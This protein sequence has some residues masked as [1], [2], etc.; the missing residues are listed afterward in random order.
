MSQGKPKNSNHKA[1]NNIMSLYTL[2]SIKVQ[3][4]YCNSNYQY[5]ALFFFFSF[6]RKK[7][8]IIHND[9]VSRVNNL[10]GYN[11]PDSYLGIPLSIFILNITL[12]NILQVKVMTYYQ[13]SLESAQCRTLFLPLLVRVL[14]EIVLYNHLSLTCI[15]IRCTD[16]QI[17]IDIVLFILFTFHCH[18][19]I[20]CH[21]IVHKT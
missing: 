8:F 7:T 19:H 21:I 11:L 16:C 13:F 5:V 2:G 4:D 3:V 10:V 12:G 6:F 9:L 17:K 20:L 15:P 14:R 1:I 18:G